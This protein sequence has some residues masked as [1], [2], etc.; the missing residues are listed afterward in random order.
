M[1]GV[2][3]ILISARVTLP[4]EDLRSRGIYV[5]QKPFELDDFLDILAQM[6]S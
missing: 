1:R 2:P 3:T 4:F 5:L 6:L